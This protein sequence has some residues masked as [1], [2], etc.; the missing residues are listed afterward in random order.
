[1]GTFVGC[2]RVCTQTR[3]HPCP[4]LLLPLGGA[5]GPGSG[6][7]N[8][9]PPVWRGKPSPRER[10]RCARFGRSPGMPRSQLW[11]LHGT[12]ML[13]KTGAHFGLPPTPGA[14]LRK[15]PGMILGTRRFC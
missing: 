11:E 12:R 10:V 6:K 14:P 2:V 8:G 13:Q 4:S 7:G 1:M 5:S 3:T 9:K 15:T